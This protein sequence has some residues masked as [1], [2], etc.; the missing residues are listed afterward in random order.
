MNCMFKLGSFKT[1]ASL[2]SNSSEFEFKLKLKLVEN[3]IRV[4]LLDK[5]GLTR[6]RSKLLKFSMC[7]Q[8]VVQARVCEQ[9][10]YIY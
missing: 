5:V 6:V 4:R 7:D 1:Q 2:S 3:D 10:L 8:S 9:F